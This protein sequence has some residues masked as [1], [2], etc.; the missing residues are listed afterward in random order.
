MARE[1]IA[2]GMNETRF[3]ACA[4]FCPTLKKIVRRGMSIVPPPIPIPPKI[5]AA[6]PETANKIILII[7][8]RKI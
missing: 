7:F 6:I 3:I 2:I 8:P 5:P 1:T 4:S